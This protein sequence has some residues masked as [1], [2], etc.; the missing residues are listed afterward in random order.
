MRKFL[1][2]LI[3][4]GLC[5]VAVAANPTGQTIR[6]VE[7]KAQPSAEAATVGSLPENTPVEVLQR[8]GAWY[9]VKTSAGNGWLRMLTVRGEGGTAKSS[10]GGSLSALSSLVGGGS[11]GTPV[12]T[13]V[14]GLSEEDLENAQPNPAEFEKLQGF[15]ANREEAK[16]FAAEAKLSAQTVA[17]FPPANGQTKGGAK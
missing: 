6:P 16:A 17:Y 7:L 10:S 4:A 14:R 1:V 11:S 3:V 12:A 15:A 9:E 8:L 13:G 2:V 5:A